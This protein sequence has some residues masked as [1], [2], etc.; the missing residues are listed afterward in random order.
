MTQSDDPQ[1][2]YADNEQLVEKRLAAGVAEY[3]VVDE[4]VRRGYKKPD[5]LR[6]VRRIENEKPQAQNKA[7]RRTGTITLVIGLVAA[8]GGVIATVYE[9]ATT[10]SGFFNVYWFIILFGIGSSIAGVYQ[11]VSNSD[12]LRMRIIL[13]C[14][15]V[16]GIGAILSG[17]GFV[18]YLLLS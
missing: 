15:C 1:D 11:L 3:E 5:A 7:E 13:I 6:L 8:T 18:L 17:V 4:L 10:S 12:N 2:S 16:I 9:Y 14:A